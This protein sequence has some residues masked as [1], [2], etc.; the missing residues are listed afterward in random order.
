M[1]TAADVP[2][3]AVTVS[4]AV[5]AKPK[6]KFAKPFDTAATAHRVVTKGTGDTLAK[7][8]RITFDY[9]VIDGRTGAELG[10]VVRRRRRCRSC[11][12]ASSRPRAW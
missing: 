11:S 2:L 5:D 7:G 10:I 8:A 6:V 4:G 1:A 12:T 9:F 3:A